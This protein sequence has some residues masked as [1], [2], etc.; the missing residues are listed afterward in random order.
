MLSLLMQTIDDGCWTSNP[1]LVHVHDIVMCCDVR[2]V[3]TVTHS[4]LQQHIAMSALPQRLGGGM[5]LNHRQW[6][7][8]YL[9]SWH[10]VHQINRSFIAICKIRKW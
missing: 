3:F 7:G 8:A 1:L 9:S 6:I 4:Q 10:H 2:Q 5:Q